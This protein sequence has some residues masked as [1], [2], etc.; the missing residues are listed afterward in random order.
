MAPVRVAPIAQLAEG[1]ARM[2]EVSGSNPRLGGSKK[3][4]PINRNVTPVLG[5]RSTS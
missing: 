4:P 5:E 3:T 2:Q 1:S